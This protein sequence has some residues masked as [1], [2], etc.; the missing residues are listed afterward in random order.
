MKFYR[1]VAVAVLSFICDQSLLTKILMKRNRI[2]ETF[3]RQR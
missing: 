1:L 2:D 3:T